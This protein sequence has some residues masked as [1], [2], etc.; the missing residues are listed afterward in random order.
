MYFKIKCIAM[1][2]KLNCQQPL[3]QS[4]VSH[5]ALYADLLHKHFFLLSVLKIVVLLNTFVDLM[6]YL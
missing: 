6:I 2:E 1:M 3:L 5:D 4:S